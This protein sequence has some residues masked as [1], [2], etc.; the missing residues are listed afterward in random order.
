V[1]LQHR[2]KHV[3]DLLFSQLPVTLMHDEELTTKRHLSFLEYCSRSHAR[4]NFSIEL[5]HAVGIHFDLE[6]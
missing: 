3:L 2:T 5:K 4:L 6:K 1:K